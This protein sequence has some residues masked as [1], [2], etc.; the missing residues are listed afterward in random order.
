MDN[1]H[2]KSSGSVEEL[3]LKSSVV[4]TCVKNSTT[5]I[6]TG[7]VLNPFQCPEC[8]KNYPH[9]SGLKRHLFSHRD[10]SEWPFECQICKEKVRTKYDLSK[11]YV[12]IRHQN[13]PRLTL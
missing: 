2:A 13:D 4:T 7:T 9:N 6:S 8:G 1:Q 5:N 12:S 3:I 10:K 11:H